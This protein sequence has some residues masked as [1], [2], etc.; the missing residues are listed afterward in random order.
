MTDKPFEVCAEIDGDE[1][2][3]RPISR[4]TSKAAAERVASQYEREH[5]VTTWVDGPEADDR[6]PE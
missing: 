5:G 1:E 4:H 6:A 2:H 3:Y